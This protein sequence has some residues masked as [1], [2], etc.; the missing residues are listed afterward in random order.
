MNSIRGV[1]VSS[2]LYDRP[3]RQLPVFSER[4]VIDLTEEEEKKG[5]FPV[6]FRLAKLSPPPDHA[7]Q[8]AES[9]KVASEDAS[10]RRKSS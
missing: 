6:E 3:P 5:R 8:V 9:Q 10:L 7:A 1:Q 4:N 2:R